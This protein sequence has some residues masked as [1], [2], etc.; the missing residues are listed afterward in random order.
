[1]R[2][3]LEVGSRVSDRVRPNVYTIAPKRPFLDTLAEGLL[4]WP[5]AAR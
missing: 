3:S 4:Q 5:A 1:V 2:S